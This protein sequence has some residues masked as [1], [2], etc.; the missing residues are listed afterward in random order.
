M[1]QAQEMGNLLDK[2]HGNANVMFAQ[3]PSKTMRCMILNYKVCLVVS[4]CFLAVLIF[5]YKVLEH[6]TPMRGEGGRGVA[7]YAQMSGSLINVTKA[8]AQLVK[9]AA[10]QY[11]RGK[12]KNKSGGDIYANCFFPSHEHIALQRS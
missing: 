4:V 3:E 2:E 5:V 6:L 7:D 10:A 12:E 9:N 11:A 1:L 8:V